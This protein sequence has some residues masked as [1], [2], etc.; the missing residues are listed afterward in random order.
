MIHKKQNCWEYMKCGREPSGAKATDLGTCR[1]A[2]DTSF[3]GINNGIN[4]GRICWCIGG[5]FCLVEVQGTS[6]KELGSCTKC[7]FFKLSQA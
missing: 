3:N 2:T 4:G 5:T 6:A 1:V 7:D